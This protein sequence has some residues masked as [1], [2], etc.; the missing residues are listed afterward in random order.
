MSDDPY[1]ASASAYELM[2]AGHAALQER[3]LT[4]FLAAL[5]PADG[6]VLDIGCGSGRAAQL[7]LGHSAG[8]KVVGIEPSPAMRSLALSRLAAEPAWRERVTVRPEGALEAPWPDAL[9]GALM[10]GVLGHF[11]PGERREVFR[12]LAARLAVGA[13]LLFDLQAPDRPEAVAEHVFADTRL[14]G[15]RYQGR[16]QGEPLDDQRMR[17]TMTYLTIDGDEVVDRRSTVMTVHHPGL[18]VVRQ[19]LES[20]G[21]CLRE[22][23]GTGL[24]M[25]C[26][27]GAVTGARPPLE[28]PRVLKGGSCW[29]SSPCLRE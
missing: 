3:A 23:D 17:W 27:P 1:A 9:S 25:A 13:P 21:L 8:L 19:E 29:V 18:A 15:L 4:A 14:G 2:V 28:R 11:A 16:A 24:W 6:P 5:R 20:Q 10:L 26:R 7:L 12:R 22:V